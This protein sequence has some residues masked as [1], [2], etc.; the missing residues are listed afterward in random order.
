MR[1]D[2]Y[3]APQSSFLSIEKDLSIITGN[4]EKCSRLKRLLIEGNPKLLE[5][6]TI[7]PDMSVAQLIDKNVIKI[8]PKITI[9]KEKLTYLII[10]F[11]D[12]L[13]NATNPEYRNSILEFNIVCHFDQWNLG[14]FQL[15]PYKIAAELDSMF[16]GKYLT[17]I[18]TLEFIGA[19]QEVMT[20]EFAG[21]NLLYAV[22]HGEEDRNAYTPIESDQ[23]H[24]KNILDAIDKENRE[25]EEL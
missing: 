15:R 14:N 20:D 16:N 11:D 12:F 21:L 13:P 10:N 18:G 23:N 25:N 22:I 3:K 6:G 4:L 24:F 8:V 19:S 5:D 2:R 17:G 1:I 7:K 9:D